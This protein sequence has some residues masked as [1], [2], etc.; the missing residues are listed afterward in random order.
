MSNG[1]IAS[2]GEAFDIITRIGEPIPG[3]EIKVVD[4]NNEILNE[5]EIGRFLIRG[6]AV[7]KGYYKNDDANQQSFTEDG[8]FITGDLGFIYNGRMTLTGREKDIIIVNGLNYNNVEIEAVIEENTEVEKSFS[9]VCSVIDP[10]TQKAL[11]IAFVVPKSGI[12]TNKL[13]SDV[14]NAVNDKIMLNINYVI[15]VTKED[16]P[17]TNLGKIQR[18]KLGKRFTNK[19]FDE[20]LEDVNVENKEIEV[21][22]KQ[23]SAD[24]DISR[25]AIFKESNVSKQRV[26]FV[27][28]ILISD[29]LYEGSRTSFDFNVNS[30]IIDELKKID[31]VKNIRTGTSDSK[32]LVFF[33]TGFD[34]VEYNAS[35]ARCI[36]K[37]LKKNS[38][39]INVRYIPLTND[40]INAKSVAELE[41]LYQQGE[42]TDITEKNRVLYRFGQNTSTVVLYR[43]T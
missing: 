12:K 35:I 14:K 27:S 1:V 32:L 28:S 20:L 11:I 19:E 24:T 21:I 6:E 23:I 8:W 39:G 37:V 18:A 13:I 34:N 17:K 4:Y 33:E 30:D 40:A 15:P 42:F 25:L 9:A 43:G 26:V 3:C 2:E 41:K 29:K 16:I 7:T 38:D 22:E 5:C 31:G 36:E 10:E